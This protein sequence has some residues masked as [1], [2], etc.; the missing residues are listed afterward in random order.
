[1]EAAALGGGLE[2][3]GSPATFVVL[4]WIIVGVMLNLRLCHSNPIQMQLVPWQC[5]MFVVSLGVLYRRWTPNLWVLVK[6]PGRI[7][8]AFNAYVLDLTPLSH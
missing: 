3:N 1:M 7:I 6:C 5:L 2:N 8:C 4:V